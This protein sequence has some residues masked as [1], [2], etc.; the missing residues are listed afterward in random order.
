MIMITIIMVIHD[1][2]DHHDHDD[3]DHHDHN[4]PT[5][6][7]SQAPMCLTPEF[8]GFLFGLHLLHGY[9]IS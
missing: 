3:H 9:V 8:R 2:H 5:A 1:H 4:L 6:I 7:Y